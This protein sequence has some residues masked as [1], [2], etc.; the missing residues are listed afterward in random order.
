MICGRCPEGRRFAQGCTYCRFYGMI[1]PDSHE[2]RQERGKH[3][4]RNNHYRLEG[5]DGPE[6]QHNGGWFAGSG[7]G[8]LSGH[9]ERERIPE[10]EEDEE[11]REE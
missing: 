6:V 7:E 3:H 4:E 8:V 11:R 2:C 9:G 5:Y 10:M 1:L